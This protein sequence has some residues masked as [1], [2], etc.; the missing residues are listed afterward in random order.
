LQDKVQKAVA[1]EQVITSNLKAEVALV[2]RITK[3]QLPVRRVSV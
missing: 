3:E 1:E 2:A